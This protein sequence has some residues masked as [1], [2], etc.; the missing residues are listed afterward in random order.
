MTI[1]AAR[2][3][4]ADRSWGRCTPLTYCLSTSIWTR[5]GVCARHWSVAFRKQVFPLLSRP[6]AADATRAHDNEESISACALHTHS[7]GGHRA[8]FCGF[9]RLVGMG[10]RRLVTCACR[11]VAAAARGQAEGRESRAAGLTSPA[12]WA[13]PAPSK[14]CALPPFLV[15]P[16]CPVSA[17]EAAA[18]VR[19]RGAGQAQECEGDAA[20][21]IART[22][23]LA[24]AR[25]FSNSRE[26]SHPKDGPRSHARQ[27][28]RSRGRSRA[29][30]KATLTPSEGGRTTAEPFYGQEGRRSGASARCSTHWSE[31]VLWASERPVLA[32]SPAGEA[33]GLPRAGRQ[34]R[35]PSNRKTAATAGCLARAGAGA[36]LQ[37]QA[38]NA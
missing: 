21:A 16:V 37:A 29:E 4:A 27:R 17:L 19:L 15:A 24:L 3:A 7:A 38:S 30:A 14:A 1:A 25:R 26:P 8:S 2:R 13:S 33:E 6:R 34:S 18:N 5:A 11:V 36:G 20:A 31:S 32:A 9:A 35:R 22:S 12:S 23:A 10:E 28:I